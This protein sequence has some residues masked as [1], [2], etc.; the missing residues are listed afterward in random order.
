MLKSG[1][2]RFLQYA[3]NSSGRTSTSTNTAFLSRIALSFPRSLTRTVLVVEDD[4]LIRL[5]IAEELRDGGLNV[6]EASN[7]D[8]ALS[9]L[10]SAVPVRLLITD[11]HMPGKMDGA[12]LATLVHEMHP[13]MKIVITSGH[14]LADCLLNVAHSSFSKPYNP[15]VV[16]AGVKELMTDSE[17]DADR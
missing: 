16:V 14:Q 10:Q 6:V 9:V 12:V 7:A 8:E 2:L 15:R 11:L 5:M 17:R 4:A 13:K 1:R 3:P